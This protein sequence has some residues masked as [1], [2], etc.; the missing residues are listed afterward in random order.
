VVSSQRDMP[1]R[2][3]FIKGGPPADTDCAT[4][5]MGGPALF[6]GKQK[7]KGGSNKALGRADAVA[8]AVDFAG[9]AGEY[10]SGEISHVLTAI[11]MSYIGG[12]VADYGPTVGKA[13]GKAGIVGLAISAANS[14]AEFH[15]C[16]NKGPG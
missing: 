1:S 4:Q 15:A 2:R 5:A 8:G 14:V 16:V 7:D 3:K 12:L 13:L 9:K 10:Y 11:E 6:G